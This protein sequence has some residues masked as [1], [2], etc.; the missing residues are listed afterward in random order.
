MNVDLDWKSVLVVLLPRMKHRPN[1]V[2]RPL[3]SMSFSY[4][5]LTKPLSACRIT[6]HVCDLMP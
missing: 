2:S 4:A 1:Q 6:L 3:N 5:G